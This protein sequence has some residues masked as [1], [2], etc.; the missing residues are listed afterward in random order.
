MK[1]TPNQSE[2]LAAPPLHEMWIEL[3]DP[4]VRIC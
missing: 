4:K 1:M 3:V 2:E